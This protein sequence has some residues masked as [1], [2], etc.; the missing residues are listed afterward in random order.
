MIV[1]PELSLSGYEP[2]MAENLATYPNDSRFEIFQDISNEKGITICV[3]IPTRS[4]NG[5]NITMLIFQSNQAIQTYIKKYLHEDEFPYFES[6]EG[7]VEI[8][9]KDRDIALAICYEISV[10]S[11]SE[12]AYK[13]GAKI[14]IASVAKTANGIEKAIFQLSEISKKYSMTVLM[15]NCTGS[16]DGDVAG[17]KSS[18]WDNNGNLL[19]QMDEVSE[20]ILIYDSVKNTVNKKILN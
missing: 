2:T 15:S 16:C 19:G 3:G 4:A 9:G 11:H 13:K 7:T 1:F 10:T 5:N 18:A 6:A 8:I 14:Y 12:N 17:G 20:G